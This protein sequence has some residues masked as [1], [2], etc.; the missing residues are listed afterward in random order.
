M[1]VEIIS[2]SSFWV[3]GLHYR[4]ANENEELPALWREFWPRHAEIKERRNQSHAYG[5]VDNY[6]PKTRCMDYWAGIEVEQECRVPKGMA[7]ICLPAQ[8]YA[9]FQCTLPTLMKTLSRIYGEWLPA[10]PYTR[11]A[12][13]EFELYDERFDVD[14]ERHEMSQWIPVIRKAR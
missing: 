11:A 9:V 5:V 10:S 3:V 6:D 7:K 2:R 8:A 12:G 1:D 14:L 4:G 13:P